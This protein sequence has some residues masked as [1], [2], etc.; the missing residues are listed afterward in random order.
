[1]FEIR[2]LLKDAI[3]RLMGAFYLEQFRVLAV[4]TIL[5]KTVPLLMRTKDLRS[6]GCTCQLGEVIFRVS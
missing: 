2:L 5:R 6:G 1:M 3:V 4:T